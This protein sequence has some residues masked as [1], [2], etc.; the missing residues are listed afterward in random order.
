MYIW[1]L[2][3]HSPSLEAKNNRSFIKDTCLQRESL[4]TNN[5]A[6]FDII[7]II[8]NIYAI[9]GVCYSLIWI[10]LL[11]FTF[12]RLGVCWRCCYI[13]RPRYLCRFNL[14][15]CLS[16]SIIIIIIDS[17]SFALL[18]YVFLLFFCS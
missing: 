10:Y 5:F 3:L 6:I 7:I 12:S 18:S 2:K 17:T 8:P 11:T 15:L 9:R 13:L 14:Y 1:N 16:V 4:N